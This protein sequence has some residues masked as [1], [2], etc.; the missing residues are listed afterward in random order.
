MTQ[1]LAFQVPPAWPQLR[2][3]CPYSPFDGGDRPSRACGHLLKGAEH[4]RKLGITSTIGNTEKGLISAF[5]YANKTLTDLVQNGVWSS[6][7][8]SSK[9]STFNATTNKCFNC[10][11]EGCRPN[12][13]PEPLDKKRIK[14]NRDKFH[15]NKRKGKK[16]PHKF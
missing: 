15:N 5:N 13:C 16:H 12:T 6:S 4:N 3:F 9:Q 1:R 10:N 2:G 7:A 8:N 11:K 14:A